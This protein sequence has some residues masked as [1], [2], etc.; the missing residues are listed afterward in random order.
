MLQNKSVFIKI[1]LSSVAIEKIN[2]YWYI[3][4]SIS[5]LILTAKWPKNGTILWYLNI[6]P[7]SLYWLT[8]ELFLPRSRA[9]LSEGASWTEE[10]FVSGGDLGGFFFDLVEGPEA[11]DFICY[12]FRKELFLESR[13]ALD[14]DICKAE[15]LALADTFAL[16][17][18]LGVIPKTR[19]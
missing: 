9:L 6:F 8:K 3:L 12:G 11:P 13:P 1:R 4:H 5:K 14:S 18:K 7:K 19:F 16:D 17:L 2:F 15:D 10:D